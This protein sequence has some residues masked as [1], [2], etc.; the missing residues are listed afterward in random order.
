MDGNVHY[1]KLIAWNILHE[2]SELITFNL[3][4]IKYDNQY[5]RCDG[6]Q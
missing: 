4:V 1:A 6:I 3:L 5:D 2:Q